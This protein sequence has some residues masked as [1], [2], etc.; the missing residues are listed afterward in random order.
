M[1]KIKTSGLIR[2]WSKIKWAGRSAEITRSSLHVIKI[3][4]VEFSM[5]ALLA[6]ARGR[7]D[8]SDAFEDGSVKAA[9]DPELLSRLAEWFRPTS[10]QL[11]SS[12]AR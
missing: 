5:P 6:L 2:R 4:G 8:W 10:D 7:C 3:S 11:P 9:G 12:Y 1:S